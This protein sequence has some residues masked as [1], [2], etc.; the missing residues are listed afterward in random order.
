LFSGLYFCFFDK[1]CFVQ[2]IA[3]WIKHFVKQEQSESEQLSGPGAVAAAI[4]PQPSAM[5]EGNSVLL[6]ENKEKSME[7]GEV[8]QW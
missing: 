5:E 1:I 4:T 7:S 3:S 2:Q 8:S 6:Q